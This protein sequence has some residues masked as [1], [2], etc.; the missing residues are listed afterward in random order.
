MRDAWIIRLL[1]QILFVTLLSQVAVAVS[2]DRSSV[3]EAKYISYASSEY[4]RWSLFDSGRADQ[5]AAT[6]DIGD[7]R[8]P[9]ILTVLLP[10]SRHQSLYRAL[11]SCYFFTVPSLVCTMARI[12]STEGVPPLHPIS[13]LGYETLP[14][15]WRRWI[16]IDPLYHNTAIPIDQWQ[17][18]DGY[19]RLPEFS[20]LHR[21]Y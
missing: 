8:S 4:P 20:S 15:K 14:E 9:T 16:T 10:V 11:G 2:A 19:L 1:Q 3:N 18:M 13:L 12:N 17:Y 21:R 6:T 7:S 5:S